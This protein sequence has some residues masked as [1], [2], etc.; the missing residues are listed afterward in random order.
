MDPEGGEGSPGVMTP[1]EVMILAPIELQA[2]YT[3]DRSA[4]MDVIKQGPRHSR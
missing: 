3:M 2:K 4:G 1:S